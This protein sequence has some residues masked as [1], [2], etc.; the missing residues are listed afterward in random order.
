[1]SEVMFLL[2]K[3]SKEVHISK[4]KRKYSLCAKRSG[5]RSCVAFTEGAIK[6]WA[7][8]PV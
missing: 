8:G 7:G 4:K 6:R 3:A 1:M 5:L 2:A